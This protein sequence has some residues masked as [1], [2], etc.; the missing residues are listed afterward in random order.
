MTMAINIGDRV[1]IT[2]IGGA[3]TGERKQVGKGYCVEGFIAAPPT[4]GRGIDI[5]RYARN[6]FQV[7][8]FFNTSAVV[9]ITGSVVTTKSGSKYSLEKIADIENN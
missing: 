9:D 6:G 5:L 1:R 7:L 2:K 4:I 3:P 8:G